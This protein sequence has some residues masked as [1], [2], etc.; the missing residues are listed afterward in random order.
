MPQTA[1]ASPLPSV[2]QAHLTAH[3]RR[4]LRVLLSDGMRT[5]HYREG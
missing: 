2:Q 3:Q 1:V 4:K 5:L